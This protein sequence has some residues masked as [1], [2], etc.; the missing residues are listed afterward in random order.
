MSGTENQPT[1]HINEF[2]TATAD[3]GFPTKRSYVSKSSC[4]PNAWNCQKLNSE[5]LNKF[6]ERHANCF[7]VCN[8]VEDGNNFAEYGVELKASA[9]GG[10]AGD[11]HTRPDAPPPRDPCGFSA[12]SPWATAEA[13]RLAAAEPEYP[14][15]VQPT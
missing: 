4:W 11:E 14:R 10:N 13:A 15:V 6:V 3:A 7:A 8:A 2:Q 9:G 5:N 1:Y 12:E